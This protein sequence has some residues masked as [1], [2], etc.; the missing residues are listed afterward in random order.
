L[1]D[2]LNMD[3]N[4]FV[5]SIVFGII[6]MGYFSYGK[7]QSYNMFFYSGIGLMVF[8]YFVEGESP[9]IIVGILLSLIPFFIRI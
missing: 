2:I 5:L 8:P 9:V 4:V 6:G 7:S 3:S 1:N